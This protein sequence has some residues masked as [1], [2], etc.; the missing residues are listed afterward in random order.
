MDSRF[1]RLHDPVCYLGRE[2]QV[3]NV[4]DE[5]TVKGVQGTFIVRNIRDEKDGQ[6]IGMFGGAKNPLG[7]RS[8]RFFTADRVR[9]IPVKRS[10]RKDINED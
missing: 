9:P 2:D 8:F 5:V 3:I 7:H 6:V 1:R 4:G 10:R